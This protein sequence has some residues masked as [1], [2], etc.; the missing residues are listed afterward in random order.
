MALRRYVLDELSAGLHPADTEALLAALDQLKRAGNSLFVVDHEIDVIRHA[1]WIVDVGP[2]AGVQGVCIAPPPRRGLPFRRRNQAGRLS[3]R[4]RRPDRAVAG[5]SPPRLLRPLEHR[6]EE[7]GLSLL[8]QS[9]R[10]TGR[11]LNGPATSN[12]RVKPLPDEHGERT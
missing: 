4:A 6:R 2:A 3:R 8:R 11:V 7:L 12:L 1:D 9:F 5:V 10:P